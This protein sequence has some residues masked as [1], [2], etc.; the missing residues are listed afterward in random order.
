ML[1]LQIPVKNFK[2]KITL[3]LFSKN[4]RVFCSSEADEQI[5]VTNPIKCDEIDFKLV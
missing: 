3:L 4:Y 2:S 1:I 5:I